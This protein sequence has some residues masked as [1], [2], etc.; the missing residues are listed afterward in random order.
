M[1]CAA[2]SCYSH[3]GMATDPEFI[4]STIMLYV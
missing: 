4:L 2:Y 3:V 1:K